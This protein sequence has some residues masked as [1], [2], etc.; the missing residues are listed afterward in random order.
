MESHKDALYFI[1]ARKSDR[2][3]YGVPNPNATGSK[4]EDHLLSTLQL[5]GLTK[6]LE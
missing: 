5:F 2:C 6:L 1:K 3:V 4:Y